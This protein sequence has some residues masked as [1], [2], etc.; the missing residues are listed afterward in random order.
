[1]DIDCHFKNDVPVINIGAGE[2]RLTN[3]DI[4]D[5]VLQIISMSRPSHKTIAFNMSSHSFLNSIGLGEL[6]KVKDKL[7]DRNI[8]LVLI[9]PS[10]RVKSLLAMVGVDR[11]FTIFNNEDELR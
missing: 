10:S 1:M 9:N 11:F 2:G 4:D 5:F 7:M 8:N 3:E 6:I